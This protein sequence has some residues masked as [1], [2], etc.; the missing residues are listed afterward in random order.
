MQ[1]IG[2]Q[3]RITVTELQEERIAKIAKRLNF[4][5]ARVYRNMIDVGLDLYD[6]FEKVG[7]WKL[8]EVTAKVKKLTKEFIGRRQARL[9]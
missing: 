1:K 2:L 9:F 7:V 8:V 4:S 5:K 6:E 3:I